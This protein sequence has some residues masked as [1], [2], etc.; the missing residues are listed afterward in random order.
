MSPSDTFSATL[1]TGSSCFVA[2]PKLPLGGVLSHH[3][4]EAGGI[5]INNVGPWNAI[6][7]L[8]DVSEDKLDGYHLKKSVKWCEFPR[9]VQ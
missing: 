7:H 8:V 4:Q 6:M 1:R 2:L 9:I 3:K 5:Y